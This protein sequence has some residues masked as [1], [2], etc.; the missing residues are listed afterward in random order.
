MKAPTTGV[1]DAIRA[2]MFDDADQAIAL[3][4]FATDNAIRIVAELNDFC[5]QAAGESVAA[6]SWF[7]LSVGATF[8]VQLSDQRTVV[9]KA[10]GEH[11][12]FETLQ[13]CAAVQR[14]L[15]EGGFPCPAVLTSPVL[16]G[17]TIWSM[18]S[19]VEHK[20]SEN[21]RSEAIRRVCAN[22]LADFL[23][24]TRK[25]GASARF[26]SWLPAPGILWNR[27]HNV[28]FDFTAITSDTEI[29]D[30]IARDAKELIEKSAYQQI[31]GHAD[32][33][34]Q[35]MSFED[36]VL[37]CVYDWDSLRFGTEECFLAGAACTFS[38]NYHQE[39]VI[40]VRA[41]EAKAFIDDYEAARGRPFTS[42]QRRAIR[43]ATVYAVAYGARCV[44]SYKG[45]SRD[46]VDEALCRVAAFK[47]CM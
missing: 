7:F 12:G 25:I 35:N 5:E 45:V 31:I 40:S 8:A 43:A 18:Q 22:G 30:A 14:R 39:P 41:P 36:G 11:Q 46:K 21:T 1:A 34:C 3:S 2:G 17:K 23:H 10:H 27:P 28:L 16:R 4:I 42:E 26:D 6:C 37:V 32:W 29:I 44:A 20:M 13:S 47:E 15:H 24:L 38:N 33:S 19:H 9:V